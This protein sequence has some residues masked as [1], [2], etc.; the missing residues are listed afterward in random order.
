ML[1]DAALEQLVVAGLSAF[2]TTEVVR[3]A[4]V[5]QGALFKYFPTKSELLA[6]V[7]EHLF[8]Q[9]RA[10][11]EADFG[12]L[13]RSRRNLQRGLSLLWEQMLDTRLAAAFELY[14]AA[15]TD[16]ELQ[17]RLAPVVR[18]H[19]ARIEAFGA[20]LSEL[21][22]PARV[23][24]LTGLAISAIQGMVLNQLALP[25]VTQ[26]RQLKRDLGALGALLHGRPSS[27]ASDPPKT[28]V[29]RSSRRKPHA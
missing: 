21:G 6:A 25:D 29:S 22:D 19:L 13:P 28:Q 12:A 14:A 3:R 17:A 11:Y 7:A 9:L 18:A 27:A 20:T 16:R 26:V 24:S 1:L 2:T 15:R 5:S 10:R 4:G 8:E 23:R